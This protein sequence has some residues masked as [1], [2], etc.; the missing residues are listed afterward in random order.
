MNLMEKIKARL[1]KWL[2]IDDLNNNL[3]EEIRKLEEKVWSNNSSIS[4][5]GHVVSHN[6][7]SINTLHRTVENIV[8]IG[9]DI[10]YGT[11]NNSW[12]VI[13]IEGKMNIVKFM[14]LSGRDARE[15]MSF[16]KQFEVG[17]HCIDSPNRM[18][19]EEVFK[20]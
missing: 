5:V 16:L 10:D 9:T 19:R 4:S 6:K 18:F 3:S 14:D 13:C 1:T 11:S 20:F 15:V 8:H 7:A 17:K 2:G 12:A